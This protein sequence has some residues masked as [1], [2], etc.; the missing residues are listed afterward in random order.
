MGIYESQVYLT[1]STGWTFLFNFKLNN[2]DNMSCLQGEA[3]EGVIKIHQIG[4]FGLMF[5]G[6]IIFLFLLI[7][8]SDTH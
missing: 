3:S 4:L 1:L 6:D 2:I 7:Y 8:K 5:F